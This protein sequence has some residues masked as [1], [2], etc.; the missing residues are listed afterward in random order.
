MRRP[1]SS[2]REGHLAQLLGI[3]PGETD[4]R[5]DTPPPGTVYQASGCVLDDRLYIAAGPKSQCPGLF[6]YDPGGDRWSEVEHPV[7][8][9]NAP[10]C[11][12]FEDRV[13]VW[14]GAPTEG[15]RRATPTTRGAASGRGVRT[16]P[17]S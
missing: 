5:V 1:T 9:P 16:C 2:R 10:L 3:G 14:E 8:A 17:W 12:A 6:V 4:W 13:W 11:T 7:K 15:E